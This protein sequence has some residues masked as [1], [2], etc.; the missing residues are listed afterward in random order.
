MDSLAEVCTS[1]NSNSL[2]V[3]KATNKGDSDP[4]TIDITNYA[5]YLFFLQ[6]DGGTNYL[7]AASMA[8]SIPKVTKI[9]SSGDVFDITINNEQVT[10][11]SSVKY[12][13]C[14]VVKLS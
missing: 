5:T 3:I 1:L 14:V 10:F 11:M 9:S 4:E 6:H 8:Q 12:W 13:T 7:F 2:K